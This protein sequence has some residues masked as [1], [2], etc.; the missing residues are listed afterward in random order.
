MLDLAGLDEPLHSTSEL[1]DR[2]L[3]VNPVLMVEVGGVFTGG[4]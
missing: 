1:F 2:N 3:T 4:M